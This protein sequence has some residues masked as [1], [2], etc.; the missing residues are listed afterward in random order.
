MAGRGPEYPGLGPHVHAVHFSDEGD[1]HVSEKIRKE[2]PAQE[3]GQ[4]QEDNSREAAIEGRRAAR[5]LLSAWREIE[6]AG[7]FLRELVRIE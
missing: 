2:T 4:D 5:S 3:A 1:R 6:S 7:R